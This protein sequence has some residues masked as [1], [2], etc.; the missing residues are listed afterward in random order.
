MIWICK[1]HDLRV[2]NYRI[3]YMSLCILLKLSYMMCGS[4]L[5]V[6]VQNCLVTSCHFQA[7]SYFCNQNTFNL[8]DWLIA[9]WSLIKIFY[10]NTL[11]KKHLLISKQQEDKGKTCFVEGWDVTTKQKCNIPQQCDWQFNALLGST[12]LAIS[13]F[14]E[15]FRS[16]IILR[17]FWRQNDQWQAPSQI[18]LVFC[19]PIS[20]LDSC[21]CSIEIAEDP[22]MTSHLL[23]GLY[24]LENGGCMGFNKVSQK[25]WNLTN[26]SSPTWVAERCQSWQRHLS[27]CC[28]SETWL[29][30]ITMVS[31]LQSHLLIHLFTVLESMANPSIFPLFIAC[32]ILLTIFITSCQSSH[33]VMVGWG[34]SE[35]F[36]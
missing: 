18:P 6:W 27:S 13:V 22:T 14:T 28:Y 20:G 8:Q 12:I 32:S 21:N 23:S 17:M 4:I 36:Q 35:T 11:W 2:H 25:F 30:H 19:S 9:C 3:H 10:K 31:R 33:V 29:N 5:H 34:L 7:S 15:Q 26:A 24:H 1:N 16:L